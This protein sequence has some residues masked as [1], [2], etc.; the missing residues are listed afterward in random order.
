LEVGTPLIKSEGMDFVRKLRREFPNK[1]IVADMKIA[2]TGAIETEMASK[3]G[4]NV[5]CVLGTSSDETVKESIRSASKYG[6]KIMVDLIGVEDEV[7]RAKEVESLGVDYVCLHVAIDEQMIGKPFRHVK[8]IAGNANIPIAV[9]GGLNS[10]T[11]PVAMKN[12]ASIIIV[13]GAIIKAEDASLATKKIKE[14]ILTKKGIKTNS[15]KKYRAKELRDAFMKVSSCNVSDAM[16]RKG[17]MEGIH[18]IKKGYHLVGRALTVKTMD[19]DWAKPVEAIDKCEK[20]GVIVIDAESGRKAVWGEL[21][22]LSC[23]KKGVAGVVID[24]GVRDIHRIKETDFPVFA[25]WISPSA[26]EPKGFGEIGSEIECGGQLVREGDWIIGDDSGVVV[27]H[28]ENAQEIANRAVNV[29]EWENR[30]REEI[31]KG[32]SLGKVMKLEKWEK[33]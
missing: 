22:T 21:A 11:A 7:T 28:R 19:G 25:R 17:A 32:S 23:I 3:S 16:H 4:A 10:E 6:S 1:T 27:V 20:G 9:A 31:K 30:I 26:G 12:G 24:G 5:I 2:D 8:E 29:N 13:G 15:F 18:P 33:L 14:S